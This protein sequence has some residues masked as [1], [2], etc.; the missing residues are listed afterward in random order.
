MIGNAAARLVRH[1]LEARKLSIMI[2]TDRRRVGPRNTQS[3]NSFMPLDV[4]QARQVTIMTVVAYKCVYI[5]G[6]I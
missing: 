2:M 4:L 6:N 1:E 3:W 5:I